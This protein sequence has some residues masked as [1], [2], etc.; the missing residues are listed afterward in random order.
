MI[1]EE[2]EHVKSMWSQ[3]G[4]SQEL[5]RRFAMQLLNL[6]SQ[7]MDSTAPFALLVSSE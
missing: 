3:N 2:Q 7:G 6:R 4:M 5:Y 1:K